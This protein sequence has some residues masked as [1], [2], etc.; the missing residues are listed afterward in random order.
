[1]L[2]CVEIN[3]GSG[4]T[5]TDVLLGSGSSSTDRKGHG[6]GSTE[7][8]RLQFDGKGT[9][10]I[11]WK[12]HDSGSTE[13]ARLPSDF[14]ESAPASTKRLWFGVTSDPWELLFHSLKQKPQINKSL[15]LIFFRPL[16]FSIACFAFRFS[17][18]LHNGSR[19]SPPCPTLVTLVAVVLRLV[20]PMS[21]APISVSFD[22]RTLPA[23]NPMALSRDSINEGSLMGFIDGHYFV[24]LSGFI[25]ESLIY[26]HEEEGLSLRLRGN[27]QRYGNLSFPQAFLLSLSSPLSRGWW[28]Y[29]WLASPST[30]IVLTCFSCNDRNWDDEFVRITPVRGSHPFWLHDPDHQRP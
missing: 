10:S 18:H 26:N 27:L 7:R 24:D 25:H 1:M 16:S 21:S 22:S 14:S 12:G 2:T 11:R 6:F 20:P 30:S 29:S 17:F 19:S 8:A 15:N 5:A 9:A 13:R 23:N 4:S 28:I 3:N